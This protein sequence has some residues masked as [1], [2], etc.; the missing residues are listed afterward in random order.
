MK[1]NNVRSKKIEDLGFDLDQLTYTQSLENKLKTVVKESQNHE[2][3]LKQLTENFA[4]LMN[5]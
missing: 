3:Q 2:D 1:D 5:G 4:H